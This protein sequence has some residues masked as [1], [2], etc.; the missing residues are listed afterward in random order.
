MMMPAHCP[1]D[2]GFAFVTECGNHYID[3]GTFNDNVDREPFVIT[4][5]KSK[6]DEPLVYTVAALS[7]IS[8]GYQWMCV[9]IFNDDEHRE[10]KG[11]HQKYFDDILTKEFMEHSMMYRQCV[12]GIQMDP[13]VEQ[14]VKRTP[15]DAAMSE[16]DK[17]VSTSK[18]SVGQPE[19]SKAILTITPTI[20]EGKYHIVFAYGSPFRGP[21]MVCFKEVIVKVVP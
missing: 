21:K 19:N 2:A 12:H 17:G 11:R 1:K 7:Q 18:T 10:V 4:V 15:V 5:H 3:L 8:T 13:F 16:G 14:N 6:V 9:G 20:T